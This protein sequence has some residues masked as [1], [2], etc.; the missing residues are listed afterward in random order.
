[1]C[2][3]DA[4]EKALTWFQQVETPRYMEAADLTSKRLQL[5]T[6]PMRDQRDSARAGR[7]VRSDGGSR[8]NRYVLVDEESCCIRVR[9]LTEAHLKAW[10]GG[11]SI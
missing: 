3:K 1:M 5:N 2:W 9:D 7:P 8:M 4:L 10:L 6:P 11:R